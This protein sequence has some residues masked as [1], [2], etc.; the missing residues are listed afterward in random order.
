M[1]E[2]EDL[3]RGGE[4][5][6][7]AEAR[8]TAGRDVGELAA[9]LGVSYEAYRDVEWFDDEIVGVL[10]FAQLLKVCHVLGIEPRSFFDAPARLG[11]VTFEELA[12]RLRR[13]APEE[14]ADLSRLEDEVGWELRRQLAEPETFAELPAIALADIGAP[15]GLDWRAFLPDPRGPGEPTS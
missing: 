15:L 12:A 9:L 2:P 11:R 13:L 10:S 7:L 3:I 4:G 14:D 1:L 6:R 5:E 8:R